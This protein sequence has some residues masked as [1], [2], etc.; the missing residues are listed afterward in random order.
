MGTSLRVVYGRDPVPVLPPSYVY[1]HVQGAIHITAAGRIKLRSRPWHYKFMPSLQHHSMIQYR[2]GM[3]AQLPRFIEDIPG[4]G[5]AKGLLEDLLGQDQAD[6]GNDNADILKLADLQGDQDNS[7]G[8]RVVWGCISLH[9][10]K[11]TRQ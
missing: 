2:A 7:C 6:E 5:K 10:D 3:I 4:L 9:D 11:Q 1:H 8:S